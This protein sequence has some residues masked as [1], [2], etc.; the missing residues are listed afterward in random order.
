MPPV[1]NFRQH[2]CFLDSFLRGLETNLDTPLK[3]QPVRR[4]QSPPLKGRDIT[5]TKN[6]QRSTALH[7]IL[8]ACRRPSAGLLFEKGIKILTEPAEK[9]FLM[10]AGPG[11][12]AHGKEDSDELFNA[13]PAL[14]PGDAAADHRRLPAN[15]G[16]H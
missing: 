2:L 4:N 10:P 9:W 1:R 5:N 7:S 6:V 3:L 14:G 12:R 13:V 11:N 15:A 8:P 16:G